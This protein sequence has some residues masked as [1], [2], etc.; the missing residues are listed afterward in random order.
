[1]NNNEFELCMTR[2]RM[3]QLNVVI[4]SLKQEL[5]NLKRKEKDL[6]QEE[7]YKHNQGHKLGNFMDRGKSVKPEE[8][9]GIDLEESMIAFGSMDPN[10]VPEDTP[11]DDENNPVILSIRR[12]T[13]GL[14]EFK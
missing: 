7:D 4:A 3:Q 9:T 12:G 8:K 6:E 1:M 14:L 5:E 2:R 13:D 11:E 10:E